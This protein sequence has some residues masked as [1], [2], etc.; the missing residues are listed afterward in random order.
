MKKSPRNYILIV[1]LAI[2]SVALLACSPGTTPAPSTTV[3]QS[4]VKL[5]F[6]V[7]PVGAVAGSSF[8]TQ[9]VVAVEDANG[10]V[11]TGSRKVITLSV[12]GV[13]GSPPDTLFGHFSPLFTRL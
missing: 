10:N 7:Q 8:A 9:P 4:A 5:A 13:K 6:T 11:V 3:T 1:L 12:A 2:A